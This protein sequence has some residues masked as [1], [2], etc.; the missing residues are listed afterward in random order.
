MKI[1]IILITLLFLSIFFAG[2]LIADDDS[3]TLPHSDVKYNS[4]YLASEFQKKPHPVGDNITYLHP[5]ANISFI[6]GDQELLEKADLII[7]GT[8]KEIKPSQWTPLDK[9]LDGG[10][11]KIYTE[12][13]FTVNDWA[14]GD[15]ENETTVIIYG[16]Q[17]ESVV[18][19]YG[20]WPIF[21]PASWDFEEGE[22]YLLYLNYL[23]SYDCYIMWT[24]D[25]I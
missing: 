9:P 16:G 25:G 17:I 3:N 6:R 2:C 7:Y 8:V 13:T 14:K 22:I 5:S 23:E 10:L 12:I 24:V 1:K 15:S 20:S 11:V 19:E 4:N 21:F 18:F